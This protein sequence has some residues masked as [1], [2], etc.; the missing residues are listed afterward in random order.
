MLKLIRAKLVAL[1]LVGTVWAMPAARQH[2]IEQALRVRGYHGDMMTN[3]RRIAEEHGWQHKSVP[4]SRV[5]I[6]L[7]L[8]P[9]YKNILNPRT[10]WTNPS[11]RVDAIA[12]K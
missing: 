1:V 9:Q 4:D 7:G 3:L 10:A 12:T 6:F 8:G 2:Q 5:L 11:Y